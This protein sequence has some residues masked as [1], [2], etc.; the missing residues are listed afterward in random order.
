MAI[1]NPFARRETHGRYALSTYR[2]LVP[3]TWL[4]VVIFGVYYTLHSPDDVKHGRK[5]FKQGHV[6]TTPFSLNTT[7]TEIYWVLLLLTQLSY[8][9]HLFSNDGAIANAA[10]NVG[11]HF[12][13]NNLF[14]LAWI[15][16]W[17]RGHFWASEVM[18]A[19]N[20]LNQHAAYWRHRTLPTFV[21]L[22]A[23]AGPYAWTLMALFWNGAVAVGSN[24]FPAR[25]AANIFIWLIFAFGSTH[26]MATQD[27]LLGY[28]LTF[29]TLALA[30]EQLAIKVI[31]LQWIFAFVIFAVFL[32]ESIYLSSTKYSGRDSLFRRITE[33]E[34]TDRE[35]EPLLNSAANP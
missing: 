21:H 26:I 15:L 27:D 14:T 35:R 4:L 34:P 33:P 23:I 28:C 8:V 32:V 22:S 20:Y 11:S 18:L 31:A 3:I 5:I 6:Y 25:I 10:A 24:S 16:L 12:I 9:Y 7:I 30:I 17:T 13:L 2:V 1:Y 29:L 19:A